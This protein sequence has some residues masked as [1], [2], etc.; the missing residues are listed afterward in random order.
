MKTL[1]FCLVFGL[2]YL[3]LTSFLF[4][5]KPK[6]LYLKTIQYAN[7]N[8]YARGILIH[9]SVIYTSNSNGVIYSFNLKNSK[10]DSY[11]YDTSIVKELRDLTLINGDLYAMH[12]G[13]TG[14]LL[15][16]KDNHI[17]LL[18]SSI[19]KNVFL[20]GIDGNGSKAFMMGDPIDEY[21][22]LFYFNGL[23]W[24]TCEGKIKAEKDEA[25]FAASGTNV[26]FINEN[27]FLFV[28]GGS[29]S[30]LFKTND[31]GKTWAISNIPFEKGEGIGAFSIHFIDSLNGVVVGGNYTKPDS[32]FRTSFYTNDGG[33]NWIE[34]TIPT[35][36]YR[37]CVI[38]QRGIFYACGTNGIDYSIDNGV[39][40]IPIAKGVY[41]ALASDSNHLYATSKNGKIDV[42]QL[43]K[44]H[45]FNR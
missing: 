41:F 15:A 42:F 1:K 3:G 29:N 27:T 25:G 35:N 32:K 20:D 28:S 31:T 2:I 44:K 30:R 12:S 16:L 7:E 9:D 13:N 36:G 45:G 6:T 10:I 8:C 21:F 4:P 11:S 17:Q 43:A 40:W 38:Y 23:E 22:S 37:S 34:S 24:T 14:L 33:K 19:W 26:Q 5:K 18:D 39:T